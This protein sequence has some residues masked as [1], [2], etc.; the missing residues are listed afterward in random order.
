M[1]Q[2]VTG[3]NYKKTAFSKAVF[4]LMRKFVLLMH[5]D[6]DGHSAYVF[7][8]GLSSPDVLNHPF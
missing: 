6:V 2:R 1:N 3:Q 5:D 8:R 7:E 4:L